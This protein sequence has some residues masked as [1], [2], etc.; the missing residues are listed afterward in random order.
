MLKKLNI[1]N[2]QHNLGYL[3]VFKGHKYKL[4][5]TIN[6]EQWKMNLINEVL[7]SIDHG[8]YAPNFCL[9]EFKQILDYLCTN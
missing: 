2:K 1:I 5:S 9:Y 7:L 6:F 3:E 8:I 4:K